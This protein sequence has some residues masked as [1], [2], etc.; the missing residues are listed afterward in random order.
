MA[1][2]RDDGRDHGMDA[3]TRLF[4]TRTTET[5]FRAFAAGPAGHTRPARDNLK[6]VY[7]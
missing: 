3:R 7:A 1:G 4:V 5:L 6:G 2:T